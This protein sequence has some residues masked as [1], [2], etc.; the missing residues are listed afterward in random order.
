MTPEV[1]VAIRD[2]KL[3]PVAQMDQGFI[4]RSIRTQVI[5]ELFPGGDDL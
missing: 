2:K 1:L 4:S 3:L 5:G